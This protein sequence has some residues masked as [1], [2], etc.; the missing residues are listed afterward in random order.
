MPSVTLSAVSE[1]F[2]IVANVKLT[3]SGIRWTRNS[4]IVSLV[5][6]EWTHAMLLI[7]RKAFKNTFSDYMVRRRYTLIYRCG[8]AYNANPTAFEA[9]TEAAESAC[10]QKMGW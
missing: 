4:K 9:K 2:L 8:A 3:Q 5:T 1:I 10:E 6:K 7:N